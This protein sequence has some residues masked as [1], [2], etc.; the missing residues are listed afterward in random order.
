MLG[1]RVYLESYLRYCR[2]TSDTKKEK[3]A[4]MLLIA[5]HKPQLAAAALAALVRT[6]RVRI[7]RAAEK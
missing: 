2:S 4:C 1:V 5:I 7:V 3:V 6:G